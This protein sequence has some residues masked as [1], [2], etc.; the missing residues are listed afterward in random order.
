MDLFV[1]DGY[2]ATETA[3]KVNNAFPDLNPPMSDQNVHQIASRFRRDLRGDLES[4]EMTD[5]DTLFSEY[6]EAHRSGGEADP[7]SFLS[8]V[9]GTDRAELA[10]LID[11]YLARSPGRAWDAAAFA[12]SPAERVTDQVAAEW[13]EW[14]LAPEVAGWQELLPA[15]R[16]KASLKRRE[17]VERLAEGLGVR[18]QTEKVAAYYH[19]METGALPPDGVSN[20]VLDALGSILGETR[21]RLRAAGRSGSRDRRREPAGVVRAQGDGR[22]RVRRRRHAGATRL[23]RNLRGTPR[24]TEWTSSSPAGPTRAFEFKRQAQGPRA[25]PQVMAPASGPSPFTLFS[26][27]LRESD[28]EL[29][30]LIARYLGADSRWP[31]PA[32]SGAGP[33]AD[34]VP[35]SPDS[36]ETLA[37]L[38]RAQP[39]PRTRA[40]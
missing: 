29:A 38:G 2:D 23:A 33:P 4:A 12:G 27:A 5:V 35:G 34:K 21:D 10:A 19:E 16:N 40:A 39:P 28:W 31:D 32:R 24:S 8:Q 13:D 25:T 20:K 36:L 11:A 1:I 3:E 18:A 7:S 9:E 30:E 37:A 17:V 26:F 22:P 14:E 6:R 15:L